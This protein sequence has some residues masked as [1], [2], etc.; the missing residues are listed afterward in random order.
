MGLPLRGPTEQPCTPPGLGPAWAGCPPRRIS[1]PPTGGRVQFTDAGC[2]NWAIPN[3][4]DADTARAVAREVDA[5]TAG[6]TAPR[7]T[8]GDTE[9]ADGPAPRGTDADTARAA[10]R[11]VD[12]D[13]ASTWTARDAEAD[14]ASTKT[15]STTLSAIADLSVRSVRQIL[16]RL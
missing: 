7:N 10:A 3:F 8:S 16:V 15:A 12:A 9:R 4:P 14:T 1:I 11:E 5:D 13:T 2:E 6:G